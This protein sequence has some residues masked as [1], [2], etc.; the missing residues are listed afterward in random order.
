MKKINEVSQ[1]PDEI[2]VKLGLK[3]SVEAGAIIAKTS[4]EG[5]IEVTLKW[6]KGKTDDA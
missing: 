2:E 1:K 6:T 4:S 5:N 3:F